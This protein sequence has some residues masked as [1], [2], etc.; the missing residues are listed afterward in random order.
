M[1][2]AVSTL[3]KIMGP[4]S[5]LLTQLMLLISKKKVNMTLRYIGF[6]YELRLHEIIYQPMYR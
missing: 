2:L 1:P 4:R 5:L 3:Q 6:N